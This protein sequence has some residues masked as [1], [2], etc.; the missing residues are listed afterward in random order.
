MSNPNSPIMQS[1]RS[2]N[3]QFDAAGENITEF[4]ERQQNGE[5]PDPD[6]FTL[7]L[8]QRWAAKTALQAQF[9]LHEKP[10]HTVLNET[11]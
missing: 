6:Q 5:E 3:R 11:R 4:R 10:L 8:S 1:L 9:Q 2:L 7:L